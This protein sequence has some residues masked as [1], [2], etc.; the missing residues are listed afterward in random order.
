MTRKR[1]IKTLLMQLVESRNDGQAIEELIVERFR[2]YR[3]ERGAA[4]SL[5]ITQQAFNAWKYRLNLEEQ[6]NQISQ[7]LGGKI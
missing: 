1:P 7:E 3:T 5:G 6:I 4:G 2:R